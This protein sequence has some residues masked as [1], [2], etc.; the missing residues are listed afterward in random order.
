MGPFRKGTIDV[1]VQRVLDFLG[2]GATRLD[3]YKDRAPRGQ[4]YPYPVRP[5]FP[6]TGARN[7]ILQWRWTQ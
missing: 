1:H 4:P 3:M 7:S 5:D 6:V 2:R